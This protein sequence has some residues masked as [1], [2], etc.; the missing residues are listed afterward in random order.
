MHDYDQRDYE[1]L[2]FHFNT[3]S[4]TTYF[5]SVEGIDE[6]KGEGLD[7]CFD[8]SAKIFNLGEYLK[9]VHDEHDPAVLAGKIAVMSKQISGEISNSRSLKLTRDIF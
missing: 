4:R 3:K 1:S 9:K 2:M 8:C 5:K 6:V 7:H